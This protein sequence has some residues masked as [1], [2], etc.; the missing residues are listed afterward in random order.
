MSRRKQSNI[1]YRNYL[2]EL[3][4]YENLKREV[5][6][7]DSKAKERLNASAFKAKPIGFVTTKS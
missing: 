4:I 7:E 2:T 1:S 3:K 5:N 6:D